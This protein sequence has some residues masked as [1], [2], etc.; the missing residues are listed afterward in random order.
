MFSVYT[1]LGQ[2]VRTFNQG[3]MDPGYYR[4]E[5]DGNNEA[6]KPVGSGV[7]LYRIE[8]APLDGGTTG[9]VQVKKML[10]LK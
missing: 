6:G 10:L 9:F 4:L 5:W 7:Y 3:G 2:K 8:A 1:L